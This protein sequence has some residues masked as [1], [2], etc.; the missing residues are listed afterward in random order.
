MPHFPPCCNSQLIR[1]KHVVFQVATRSCFPHKKVIF[2][3]FQFFHVQ[4][5]K[6]K[7][8]N[9]PIN[10]SINQSISQSINQSLFTHGKI[11]SKDTLYIKISQNKYI[12]TLLY[13]C[14]ILLYH[15][16]VLYYNTELKIYKLYHYIKN[17]DLQDCRVR[18]RLTAIVS[19]NCFLEKKKGCSVSSLVNHKTVPFKFN[20][21]SLI[22]TMTRND[23]INNKLKKGM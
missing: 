17:T 1:H 11:S 15:I 14:T 5:W 7:R 8:E 20:K 23:N 9:Y 2:I 22:K 6:Y 12:N 18:V 3:L 13:Y 21:R 19:I 10:Q 4:I 16:I